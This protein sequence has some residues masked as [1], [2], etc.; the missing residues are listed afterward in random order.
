[1]KDKK[2]MIVAVIAAAAVFLILFVVLGWNA[3]ICALLSIGVYFGVFFLTKPVRKIAGI[4]VE[5]L[6][7]GEEIQ[8]LFD[9]ARSD[10]NDIKK[11]TASITEPDVRANAEKLYDTGKKILEYLNENPGKVKLARRFFTYYLDTA[12]RLLTR[13]VDFSK[14]GLRSGEVT[15]ILEKTEESLPLLNSA[16]EKQF[17]NLMEGELL[18]VESDIELLRTTLKM[19]DG[20]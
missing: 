16:F 18:D 11:A 5:D 2:R 17:A 12:S 10:L 4:D 9:E 14:T 6:P 7:G 20:K 1:M 15:G 19:E 8:D 3:V 13:Y